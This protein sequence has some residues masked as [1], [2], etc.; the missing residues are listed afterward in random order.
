MQDYRKPAVVDNGTLVLYYLGSELKVG[1]AIAEMGTY[2]HDRTIQVY[3]LERN[4]QHDDP[5]AYVSVSLVN[6]V[7]KI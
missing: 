1:N 6:Y 5:N 2:R 4:W 3:G 7:A